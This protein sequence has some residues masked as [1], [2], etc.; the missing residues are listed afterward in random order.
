MDKLES[1]THVAAMDYDLI[2]AGGGVNGQVL[3]LASASIG[4]RVLMVDPAKNADQVPIDGRAYSLS[5]SSANIFRVLGLWDVLE[6]HAQPMLHIKVS[7]G[8]AGQGAAPFVLHF[9]SAELEEGP[10]AYLLE[11][12]Y[13]RPALAEAVSKSDQITLHDGMTVASFETGTNGVTAKLA[14][15]KSVTASVLV[16]CDGRSSRVAKLAGI[17]RIGWSYDQIGLVTTVA[18]ERPHGGEAHQFFTPSGI[19]AVLPLTGDRSSIVWSEDQPRAQTLSEL[20]DDAFR[21][22]LQNQMGGYLGRIELA[23]GRFAYPLGL[24]L[25]RS[26]VSDRVVL[27]GDAAHGIHPLAGQGLNL[28]LRDCAALAQVL[29]EAKRRGQELGSPDVLRRYE[30]WRRPDAVALALATDKLQRI[31]RKQNPIFSVARNLGMGAVNALPGLRRGFMRQAA[32]LQGD[33]PLLLQGRAI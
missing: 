18:H 7:E 14:I 25:A 8:T 9:D 23:G 11:D 19:L 16:G 6:P 31:Y 29:A 5:L 30:I 21:T 26:F 17:S 2:I 33:P 3:A 4:L 13:L 12:E 24:S 20:P 22:A 27:V 32:G 1:A 28:G 15:G 10:M